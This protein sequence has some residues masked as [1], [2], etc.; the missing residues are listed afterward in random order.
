MPTKGGFKRIPRKGSGKSSGI[1]RKLVTMSPPKSMGS[2]TPSSDSKKRWKRPQTVRAFASQ[3]NAVCTQVL[4]GEIDLNQANAFS[5]LARVVAQTM[6]AESRKAM[7]QKRAP[8]L[9]FDEDVFE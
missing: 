6:T 8:D 4:N 9:T 1:A 3:V 2:P 5:Q 7:F